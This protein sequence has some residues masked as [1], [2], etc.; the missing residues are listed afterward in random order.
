MGEDAQRILRS[1]TKRPW[2]PV[3]QRSRRMWQ[4]G[5]GR[6]SLTSSP[7]RAPGCRRVSYVLGIGTDLSALK[8]ATGAL[9]E[10]EAFYRMLAE[11]MTVGVVL[12]QE[13]RIVFVNDALVSMLG[14]DES[15]ELLGK[16]AVSLA[17][18][19]PNTYLHGRVGC[20]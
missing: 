20:P 5:T 3:R 4:P 17:A 6:E 15:K 16:S 10:S 13:S 11:R 9:R 19:G 12:A 2:Q 8:H 1:D 7:E 14:Y 18:S